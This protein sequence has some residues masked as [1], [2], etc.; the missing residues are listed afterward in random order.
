MVKKSIGIGLLVCVVFFAS[1][2][3]IPVSVSPS[4]SL[5]I[6]KSPF[7]VQQTLSDIKR[8]REWDPSVI[9]DTTVSYEAV[10]IDGKEG[11]NVLDSMNNIIAKYSVL[12]SSIEEVDIAVELKSV[13]SFLYQFK[14]KP[15]DSGTMLTWDLSLEVNL[16]MFL[17]SAEDRL[18][19]I[20][21]KGLKSFKDLVTKT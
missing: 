16:M 4:V 17:F 19:E 6:E 9:S 8:F 14:L 15:T 10:V 21:L 3:L 12:S 13:D 11:L 1:L 7:S 5:E 18:E 2:I 20:F